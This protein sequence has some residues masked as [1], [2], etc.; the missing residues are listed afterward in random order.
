ML[1]GR[2]VTLTAGRD[3]ELVPGCWVGF[4]ASTRNLILK[5]GDPWSMDHDSLNTSAIGAVLK[6]ARLRALF[7]VKACEGDTL[8]LIVQPAS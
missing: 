6:Q 7:Q 3:Q 5:S 4:V 8:R 1:S 2:E